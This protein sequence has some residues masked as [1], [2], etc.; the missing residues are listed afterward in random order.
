[1]IS[2]AAGESKPVVGGYPGA[3]SSAGWE[4]ARE[5][6][7]RAGKDWW[8][9]CAQVDTNL[10]GQEAHRRQEHSPGDTVESG[11]TRCTVMNSHMQ[12]NM[13]TGMVENKLTNQMEPFPYTIV[14]YLIYG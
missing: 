9:R 2:T 6:K 11:D 3:S 1:M 14:R 12:P 10:R 7:V 13:A 8:L 5:K 4:M